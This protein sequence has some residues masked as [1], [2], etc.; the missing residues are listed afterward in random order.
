MK[1]LLAILLIVCTIPAFGQYQYFSNINQNQIQDNASFT[2]N[3]CGPR[4]QTSFK[5]FHLVTTDYG[6]LSY[7]Q[8]IHL[9]NGDYIGIGGRLMH[10]NR[11]II[12]NNSGS[13]LTSYK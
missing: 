1:H 11:S 5:S 4:L 13:I 3:S 6:Y 7:D 8:P 2:G 10:F 9:K 12:N